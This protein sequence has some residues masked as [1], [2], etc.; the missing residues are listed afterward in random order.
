MIR[1]ALFNL[2]IA[3]LLIY[4][5]PQVPNALIQFQLKSVSEQTV[6]QSRSQQSCKTVAP[7]Y[8]MFSL[9]PRGQDR[10]QSSDFIKMGHSGT[11]F[12][13]FRLF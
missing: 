10:P 4:N 6:S 11:L 1:S 3:M 5:R 9:T 13:S 8:T 2:S 12:V 7:R